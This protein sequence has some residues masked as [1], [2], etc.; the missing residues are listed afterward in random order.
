MALN[1]AGLQLL[2][3][4]TWK[5]EDKKSPIG[6]GSY[7]RVIKVSLHGT[8]CA[9]KVVHKELSDE[10]EK[11]Q[12]ESTKRR[13]IE[14]CEKNSQIFH[15]NVVQCLGIFTSSESKLPWLIMEMMHTS[16]TKLIE[17]HGKNDRLGLPLHIKLSILTDV[18]QGLQ[19]LHSQ[20]IIHRDLSSNNVLLTKQLAAKIADFGMAKEILPELA[21]Q[22]RNTKAPGGVVFMSPE[23]LR[24]NPTYGKPLDIF[25]LGCITL[26]LMSMK[27]PAPD[28][29]VQED[30]IALSEIERR[31]R[32]ISKLDSVPPLRHLVERCLQ[33]RPDNRPTIEDISR[34]FKGMKAA[35]DQ[36][37]P[38]ASDNV[39][40]LF[41]N[42]MLTQQELHN[43]D[44]EMDAQ[45]VHEVQIIRQKDDIIKQKDEEIQRL[46]M[47]LQLQDAKQERRLPAN[48]KVGTV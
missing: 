34:Q 28:F 36:A 33:N 1:R 35:V 47:L 42:L 16:L 19:Y 17:K 32:Y 40:E 15:P 18:S 14:E 37:E 8:T 20:N 29:P 31:A 22:I 48:P 4:V 44:A 9:A 26:H 3:G 46:K 7:G 11:I 6:E 39:A 27:W 45:T 2:S 12:F 23:A 10:V 43:R 41:I 25:S 30:N 13:F 38:H 24:D 21:G 5:D